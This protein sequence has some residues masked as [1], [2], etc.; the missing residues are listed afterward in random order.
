MK[1]INKNC[2]ICGEKFHGRFKTKKEALKK[3]RE[4]E[5]KY[6]G[7]FAPKR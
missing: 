4:A 6:F 7:E 3:R 2:E 5:F 1:K